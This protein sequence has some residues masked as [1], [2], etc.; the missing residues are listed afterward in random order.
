MLLRPAV[1]A[2]GENR[3]HPFYRRYG[4]NLPSSLARLTPDTPEVSRLG[5]LCRF[6]VRSWGILPSTL[7]T[8]PRDRPN[9][10]KTGGHSCFRL[11]L[12]ITALPRLIQ[13]DGATA[14]LDLPRDVGRWA[15]RRR[16]EYP[17]G[18]GILT[19]FPFGLPG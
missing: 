6:L 13:L 19:G 12:A 5:H 8:G 17:H 4:A 9:R 3:R 18:T 7:F 1:P 11:V 2:R 14:P 10:P 16:G 15:L